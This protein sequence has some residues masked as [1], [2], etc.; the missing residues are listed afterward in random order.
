VTVFVPASAETA[1]SLNN[2][3]G[4]SA[5]SAMPM[6]TDTNKQNTSAAIKSFV[7]M[8][9]DLLPP[10]AIAAT[11]PVEEDYTIKHCFTRQG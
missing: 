7:L 4:G 3:S 9:I 5:D 11:A 1:T 8:R 2:S 10:A 6:G